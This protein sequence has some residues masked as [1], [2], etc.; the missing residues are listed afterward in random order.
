M[1]FFYKNFFL[2]FILSTF[3]FT[4]AIFYLTSNAYTPE[5]T[6][7]ILTEETVKF[8]N[9]F[10]ERKITP[11]ELIQLKRGVHDEDNMPRPINHFYDPVYN[12]GWQK[13]DIKEFVE[14][15]DE[16]C[17]SEIPS[18][19]RPEAEN[20]IKTKT[21]K[22]SSEEIFGTLFGNFE[23]LS[24]KNW[25]QN[26]EAQARY[27]LYRGNQ[28]WQMALNEY[29]KGNEKDAF[30]TLGFLFH[31]IEDVLVPAHSRGDTHVAFCWK[32]EDPYEQWVHQHLQTNSWA[33]AEELKNE[34]KSIPDFKNLDE[35]F[36]ENANYSNNYFFSK[37]TI[38][39][40]KYKAPILTRYETKLSLNTNVPQKYYFAP[41]FNNQ[42]IYL[43]S[44]EI[45]AGKPRLVIDDL[46]N[47]NN[48][49]FLS[50][51]AVLSGAGMLKLFFEEADKIKRG[52]EKV[53][54]TAKSESVFSLI[55]IAHYL[56]PY[57]LKLGV[58]RTFEDI[59]LG[60][61]NLGKEFGDMVANLK[62]LLPEFG[63]A[64]IG[65]IG[66]GEKVKEKKIDEVKPQQPPQQLAPE[67]KTE[68]KTETESKTKTETN[69]N[70]KE[71]Q[72]KVQELMKK[73]NSLKQRAE[74]LNVGVKPQ[75]PE[76]EEKEEEEKKEAEA[77]KP[78][79]KIK[80]EEAVL[81]SRSSN[82]VPQ[83]N[84]VLFN[85]LAWM[86][87][88][89]SANDEWIELKNISGQEI[90]LTGW[91]ILDKDQQIK[92]IFGQELFLPN[93]LFL[94]ERTDD[95]SAPGAAADLIYTGGLKNSDE[96]LYLFDKNCQL[97]DEVLANS[98]WPA[99][100]N[101]D[102]RTMERKS[103]LTPEG[104]PSGSYGAG[105]Q[106]SANPGGTARAGNSSGYFVY[107]SAGGGG[108]PPPPAETH[109]QEPQIT[110]SYPKENPIDKEI[111]VTFSA[112]NLKSATYDVKIS[113]ENGTTTLSEIFNQKI[114]DWQ[115]STR[116]A[117]S[118]FS[119][120]SFSGGFK[121]R[122]KEDK[123]DFRGEADIVAKIRESGKTTIYTEFSGKIN[124][125]EPANQPP[126]AFFT[127]SHHNPFVVGE[128]I[129]FDASSST[130][131]DGAIA[132]Y[133]WD[134][135]GN[136]A[137]AGATTSHAFSAVGTST[138]TLFVF[139]DKGATSST[140]TT[141]S[142]SG[143]SES[144]FA[145]N[146]VISEVQIWDDQ[147][148][149]HDFIELYNSSTISVDISGFQLKKR[150]SS[151]SEDSIRLFP[152]GSIISGQGYFLWVNSNFVSLMNLADAT[153]SQTLAQNN[154][155]ALL[156]K[157]KNIIDAVAW[158]ISINPFVE[159]FS[160]P[161]NPE[162]GKTLARKAA[163]TSEGAF[164][165]IDTDNNS[166]D[167]EIQDPTPKNKA[168]I[169][170]L[171]SFD[172]VIENA[173]AVWNLSLNTADSDVLNSTDAPPQ[174]LQM[175]FVSNG[176][177]VWGLDSLEISSDVIDSTDALF[178]NLL[179]VFVSFAETFWK[180]DLS[181]YLF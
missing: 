35:L 119:G 137:S 40:P 71:T 139:D 155:I 7:P 169:E 41:D 100:N 13:E 68:L 4:S 8:Y 52:E 99:G 126:L 10:S 77:E 148:T 177:T 58:K 15:F 104:I 46:I 86:G 111:E 82:A 98:D 59:I 113:I 142:V 12:Q 163:T 97:Q 50:R 14:K 161:Q 78:R 18:L 107:S 115:S 56:E 42:I 88:A 128:E 49:F 25:S 81:C 80:S 37:D 9:L 72:E 64:N 162:K 73:I 178:Q 173:G 93:G 181:P 151:G 158:G 152:T 5:L 164:T 106:T 123:K 127:F 136:A 166:Q 108:T 60:I 135:G 103:D 157:N 160:F 175:A 11:E 76:E 32:E 174:N 132:A 62:S 102:K 74:E 120:T 109:Q 149:F 53:E 172:I 125:T 101:S 141:I 48:W 133:I 165:Y 170:P 67:I 143:P 134:F 17:L 33:V 95:D 176:D 3:F 131:P 159:N 87:T 6:H 29:V 66:E 147:E 44:E 156:D 1:K 105:W 122:I 146:V 89:N 145:K 117:T 92:I 61:K 16:K 180:F 116:Y 47:S 51:Q 118:T 45:R 130:D 83:R 70:L 57:R 26:Q 27:A 138:L 124:I 144:S 36:D 154:S 54:E 129:L 24:A 91:Q 21:E 55:G 167:F 34:G 20:L 110:L 94:L 38:S 31:L 75:Q 179:E 22:T 90:D 114:Q 63:P 28:T 84:K 39:I 23:P 171:P 96:A 19:L 30:Y 168:I 69:P 150:N 65:G 121:L 140:S 153:T 79:E 85:E 112:S 2:L 43:A